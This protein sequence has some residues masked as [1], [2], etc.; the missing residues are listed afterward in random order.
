MHSL[1]QVAIPIK[2]W[3]AGIAVPRSLVRPDALQIGNDTG[4]VFS[5]G[6]S[7]CSLTRPTVTQEGKGKLD[8]SAR[9]LEPASCIQISC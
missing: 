1:M 2:L 3:G 4:F 7:E 5:A 8:D 9:L 6:H